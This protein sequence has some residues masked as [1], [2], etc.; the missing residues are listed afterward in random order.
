VHVTQVTIVPDRPKKILTEPDDVAYHMKV[1]E[2]DE[3]IE[4]LNAEI[5]ELQAQLGQQKSDMIDGQQAR[6]P[7]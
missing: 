3:K 7:I 1:H 6:N 4:V 5:K 2:L